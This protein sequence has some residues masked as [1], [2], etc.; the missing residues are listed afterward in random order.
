MPAM[1]LSLPHTPASTTVTPSFERYNCVSWPPS[2]QDG[3]ERRLHV[4]MRFVGME[5]DRNPR[6]G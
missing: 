6:R 2:T 5:S 1:L 4:P 3:A